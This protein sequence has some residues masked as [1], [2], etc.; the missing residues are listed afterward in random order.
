MD[1]YSWED[2]LSM[3]DFP[4]MLAMAGGYRSHW[5]HTRWISPASVKDIKNTFI[6]PLVICYFELL[7][8]DRNSGFSQQSAN[9]GSFQFVFSKRLPEGNSQFPL[10]SGWFMD[11]ICV[12]HFPIMI[13]TRQRVLIMGF[14]RDTVK[15]L[16]EYF[17]QRQYTYLFMYTVYILYIHIY[18]YMYIYICT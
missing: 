18:I 11:E 1:V 13:D 12:V 16:S 10:R 6:Y 14:H 3:V 15:M 8:M 7:K 4:A 9:G 2:H 5:H 17:V